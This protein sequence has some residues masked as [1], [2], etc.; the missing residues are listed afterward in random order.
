MAIYS[1]PAVA[2]KCGVHPITL[3]RWISSGKLVAPPKR[4]L[5]GIGV[6]VRVWTERDVERVRK[7]KAAHYRKGRGRKKRR[8]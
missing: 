1:T 3:H 7:Y 6:V 5:R 8:K 4:R 2:K